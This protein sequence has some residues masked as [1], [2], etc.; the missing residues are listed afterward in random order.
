MAAADELLLG[1]LEEEGLHPGVVEHALAEALALLRAETGQRR[2]VRRKELDQVTAELARLAD[3]VRLGHGAI[4]T[5]VAAMEPLEARRAA[6]VHQQQVA[7]VGAIVPATQ[8]AALAP[9]MRERLTQWRDMLRTHVGGA[10]RALRELLVKRAVLT[11]SNGPD[12]RF[13]E[14]TA[15][16]SL[17]RVFSGLLRPNQMVAPRAQ[18]PSSQSTS[19]GP[20]GPGPS[21]A[22]RPGHLPP[23]LVISCL[24]P[25]C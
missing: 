18:G 24:L 11:L 17:G 19:P 4:P 22:A 9:A 25:P 12:G 8:F 7:A 1:A 15:Q 21:E 23:P 20:A 3:A 2:D 10:R 5:L 13:A 6:L 16:L 14:L